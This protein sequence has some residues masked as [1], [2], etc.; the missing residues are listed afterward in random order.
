M[1]RTRGLLS[2]LLAFVVLFT[3]MPVSA[4]D[5]IPV[6]SGDGK[7]AADEDEIPV[8]ETGEGN[9]LPDEGQDEPEMSLKELAELY[10]SDYNPYNATGYK[11][12]Y[13][14]DKNVSL[15]KY[16]E[17]RLAAAA[18]SRI[19]KGEDGTVTQE[20]DKGSEE[21]LAPFVYLLEGKTAG[22]TKAWSYSWSESY[23]YLDD[24]G[25]SQT[26]YRKVTKYFA[27]DAKIS[28]VMSE[29][30]TH[31]EADG[32]IRM[33]ANWQTGTSISYNFA[34]IEQ[35]DITGIENP[36][37]ELTAYVRDDVLELE[38]ATS[39]EGFT[40]TGWRYQFGNGEILDAA[41]GSGDKE[42]KY[43]ITTGKHTEKLTIYGIWEPQH[44]KISYVG[45]NVSTDLEKAESI[46]SLYSGE[47]MLEQLIAEDETFTIVKESG[48]VPDVKVLPE[49]Y[50]AVETLV[51]PTPEEIN[52]GEIDPVFSQY[53][54]LLCFSS[55]AKNKKTVKTLGKDGDITSGDVTLYVIYTARYPI[56]QVSAN[57][58][59]AQ[60]EFKAVQVTVPQL[61][62]TDE[63]AV[64]SIEGA[65]VSAD[66]K[67]AI[68][69]GEAAKYFELCEVDE[70]KIHLGSGYAA[71]GIRLKDDV[72]YATAQTVVKKSALRKCELRIQSDMHETDD[73]GEPVYCTISFTLKVK[74]KLPKYKLSSSKG[75]LY[76]ASASGN[77]AVFRVT[78]KD[79]ALDPEIFGGEWEADLVTKNGK[80][81]AL[82]DE[83]TASVSMEDKTFV[84]TAYKGVKA[85]I[86][87][88]NTDWLKGAYVYLP[89]SIKENK[90]SAMLAFS[91]KNVLLNNSVE[92]EEASVTV[93]FKGGMAVD[94]ELL[95]LD[96]SALPEG[97]TAELDEDVIRISGKK[98][99]KTGKYKILV[100][101]EGIKKPSTLV[102]KVVDIKADKAV[103]MKVKGKIDAFMGGNLFLKPVIN[104]YGGE[105]SDV[106]LHVEEG[107]KAAY[108]VIWNGSSIELS[109][110]GDFVPHTEEE[111]ITIDITMS[112]GTI[113]PCQIKIIPVKGNVKLD[114]QNASL[115]VPASVSG[116]AASVSVNI[117]VI[118]TYTYSFYTDADTIIQKLY[119]IDLS[120]DIGRAE[121][122]I[123]ESQDNLSKKGLYTGSYHDGIITIVWEG[124]MPEKQT[125]Y[126][127][128]LN[129]TW[130]TTN[131]KYTSSFTLTVKP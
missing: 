43:L 28:D 58:P 17:K 101:Y 67:T 34:N 75:I 88:R 107:K 125:T 110:N 84:I 61:F 9:T 87:L 69:E 89:Y 52:K 81:Y 31:V 82:V 97:V 5:T 106:A 25:S 13:V 102:L 68:L 126:K 63:Y 2:I 40:F 53:N 23:S 46:S 83:A 92:N 129:G 74:S 57:Q 65:G 50:N 86:R 66:Q 1:K 120:R 90:K 20:F 36:N 78:E 51:L 80:E 59:A 3:G 127:L 44:F 42:G 118:A 41:V 79:G 71:V 100:K 4:A 26:G 130:K 39:P 30:A 124:N 117:P 112:T 56:P 12:I 48:E 91:V 116:D 54:R 21:K 113:L 22:F 123:G 33:K 60:K 121:M 85:Y 122:I 98:N 24:D 10:D 73:N 16:T 47:E 103:K 35:Y 19:E 32:I 70:R 72:D 37:D 76:S 115:A 55:S 108:D 111:T 62:N 18:N 29:I 94:P 119:T 7:M 15:S 11:M 49:Y 109:S 77:A 114:V 96:N 99:V 128:K 95:S 93:S 8:P 38:P 64:I 104:G 6:F 45:I 27:H 131:K 14:M 105:V